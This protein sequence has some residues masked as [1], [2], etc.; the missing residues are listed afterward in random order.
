MWLHSVGSI[1]HSFNVNVIKNPS[2]L[3]MHY[4]TTKN[5]CFLVYR[6]AE[7]L[8]VT[9]STDGTDLELTATCSVKLHLALC[10]QIQA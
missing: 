9:T 2:F 5:L 3:K 10:F 1:S 4:I 7:G 8:C 6:Q